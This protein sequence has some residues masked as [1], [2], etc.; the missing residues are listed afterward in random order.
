[1]PFRAPTVFKTGPT[2]RRFTIQGFNDLGT[3][4]P[5]LCGLQLQ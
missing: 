1:M 2:L 4:V 3:D 5:N